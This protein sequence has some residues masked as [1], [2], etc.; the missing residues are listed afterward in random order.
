MFQREGV[1][2]GLIAE[3]WRTNHVSPRHVEGEFWDY[4]MDY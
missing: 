2:T 4:N 3:I 1:K